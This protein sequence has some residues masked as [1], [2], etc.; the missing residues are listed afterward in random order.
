MNDAFI[1]PIVKATRLFSRCSE[2][3]KSNDV[4]NSMASNFE[5]FVR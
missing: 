3:Q 2:V 1:L 4:L 5:P